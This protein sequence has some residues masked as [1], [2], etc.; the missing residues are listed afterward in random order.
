MFVRSSVSIFVL[1]LLSFCQ[2]AVANAQETDTQITRADAN[3]LEMLIPAEDGIVQ[4]ADVATSLADAL[5]LDAPSVQ[6]MLPTGQMDLRSEAVLLVLIGIN[7]AAGD[8]ISFALVR[9]SKDRPA[10]CVKCKPNVFA[11]GQAQQMVREA[12]IAVDN[13]WQQRTKDKPLLVCLHGMRSSAEV[14]DDFRAH[15]REQGYA[16]AAVSY[17]FDHAVATSAEQL[18]KRTAEL[19]CEAK[20]QPSLAL[21]GHSM[22]GLIARE[23]TEN[24]ALYDPRITQLITIGT[25]HQGSNWASLPPLLDFFTEGDFDSSVLVDVILHQPAS[26]GLRDL[27]PN[28]E[29]LQRLNTRPRRQGVQYTTIVGT[30]SPVHNDAVIELRTALRKLDRDGSVVRLVRP[31]IAPLLDSFAELEPGKGDGVVAVE[32]AMISGLAA[33]DVIKVDVSHFQ[34]IRALPGHHEH[35]VWD[36]V[37]QRLLQ[38]EKRWRIP[39]RL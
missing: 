18:A 9:D 26:T 3:H 29:F 11:A 38:A 14:F 35:P 20:T 22:G 31:R 15:M 4:W 10:L 34:M 19:C 23:W 7:L 25:P 12:T 33:E 24:D 28:S 8:T 5:K 37:Q 30:S 13:D 1:G 2:P 16:T 17:D 6:R 32:H 21:I 39:L 36:V 27:I